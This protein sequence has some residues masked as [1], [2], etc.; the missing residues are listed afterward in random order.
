MLRGGIVQGAR[1]LG[2]LNLI[3][4]IA[5]V[6]ERKAVAQR[7]AEDNGTDLKV[8]LPR[9]A[10]GGDVHRHKSMAR[11]DVDRND[12]S[13]AFDLYDQGFPSPPPRP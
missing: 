3:D 10:L 11:L 9:P 7:R 6:N 1:D 13:V 8:D 2:E 4:E 12:L 5:E